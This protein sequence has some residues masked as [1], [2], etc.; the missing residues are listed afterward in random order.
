MD[1]RMRKNG[2]TLNPEENGIEQPFEESIGST[3]NGGNTGNA[4]GNFQNLQN[5]KNVDQTADSLDIFLCHRSD[6]SIYF[7]GLQM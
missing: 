1:E 6:L 7:H 4:Y 3:G 2:L 5:A